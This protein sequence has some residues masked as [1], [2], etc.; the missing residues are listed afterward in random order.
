[1]GFY[2]STHNIIPKGLY[3]QSTEEKST[4]HLTIAYRH[5]SAALLSRILGQTIEEKIMNT[6]IGL[7]SLLLAENQEVSFRFWVRGAKILSLLGYSPMR[8]QTLLKLAYDIR[9][10]FVRGDDL[11]LEKKLKKLNENQHNPNSFLLEILDYLRALIVAMIF[12]STNQDFVTNKKR[13][14]YFEKKKFL[15][16]VDNAL[17]DTGQE[18]DLRKILNFR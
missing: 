8:V 15:D 3:N 14:R 18:S 10:S 13:I 12:L 7:E 2:K 11:E 5:Y 17:I 4:I 9:S 1:M 6:V 16:I